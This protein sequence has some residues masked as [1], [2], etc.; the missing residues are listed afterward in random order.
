MCRN[1]SPTHCNSTGWGQLSHPQQECILAA[2]RQSPRPMLAVV[3]NALQRWTN[4]PPPQIAPL[5]RF[6]LDEC[7]EVKRVGYFVLFVPRKNDI[8]AQSR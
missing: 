4:D 2:L 7:R 1:P 8:T 5:T 3:E 6:V